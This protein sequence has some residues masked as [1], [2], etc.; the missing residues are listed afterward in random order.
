MIGMNRMYLSKIEA[1]TTNPSFET[2]IKI[3]NGLNVE[4]V[5]L[6]NG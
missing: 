3:A 1:S 5:A 2:P 4:L 6:F